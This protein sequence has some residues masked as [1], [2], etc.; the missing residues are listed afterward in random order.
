MSDGIVF[1]NTTNNYTKEQADSLKKQMEEKGLN[2]ITHNTDTIFGE[3]NGCSLKA[4]TKETD[5]TKRAMEL[6]F[7]QEM[8][9]I[10][11][12]ILNVDTSG[13]SAGIIDEN[14]YQYLM[15][16]YGSDSNGKQDESSYKG[17]TLTSFA[18]KL[19]KP[20]DGKVYGATESDTQVSSAN[21]S[22]TTTNTT[23]T[24][25]SSTSNIN[26]TEVSQ[27]TNTQEKSSE[28]INE[29]FAKNP[30][31]KQENGQYYIETTK[32]DADNKEGFDCVSRII[33][34]TY[35]V[36][37]ASE[38][39]QQILEQLKL[40]NPDCFVNDMIYPNQRINLI[41]A[42]EILGLSTETE[43]EEKI[44]SQK[45]SINAAYQ[46]AINVIDNSSIGSED[47]TLVSTL[48]NH[49]TETVTKT[50]KLN[51]GKIVNVVSPLNE[52]A[53]DQNTYCRVYSSQENL[54]A[55][56]ELGNIVID[57]DGNKTLS[58]NGSDTTYTNTKT[59][60][61]QGKEQINE[62]NQKEALD[63]L[64][65]KDKTEINTEKPEIN[66][67]ENNS[68]ANGL[69]ETIDLSK[70]QNQEQGSTNIYVKKGSTKDGKEI[71]GYE[72]MN[73]YS[74]E[75]NPDI[76]VAVDEQGKVYGSLKDTQGTDS[77]GVECNIS[78]IVDKD[79]NFISEIFYIYDDNSYK[80]TNK[81]GQLIQT[82][83]TDETI[84]NYDP[85]SGLELERI[86]KDGNLTTFS[87]DENGNKIENPSNTDNAEQTPEISESPENTENS[88]V[89]NNYQTIAQNYKE[90]RKEIDSALA[91]FTKANY[92]DN[93]TK[94][95]LDNGSTFYEITLED[96]TNVQ[97]TKDSK[98]RILSGSILNENGNP[99]II[100]DKVEL[101][102]DKSNKKDVNKIMVKF[103]ETEGK[104][105]KTVVLKS[106][107]LKTFPEIN[108]IDWDIDNDGK[109][110]GEND[111][112]AYSSTWGKMYLDV[113][114][115]GK[116]NNWTSV[117][118]TKY[119]PQ[120]LYDIDLDRY[121]DNI[122]KQQE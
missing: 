77:N 68:N 76:L 35:H 51:D 91:T 34:N 9:D 25:N 48:E 86:D 45:D 59:E 111:I 24:T 104:P 33:Y 60:E 61:T 36:S 84:H 19:D 116:A 12:D 112:H 99:M 63:E 22:A 62:E 114:N 119:K 23:D 122:K 16:A 20:R 92:A 49:E 106:N 47:G 40:A 82:K 13:E 103:I 56:L 102:E 39:G 29:L 73:L 38:K 21:N 121:E 71:G 31:I 115:D 75:E 80:I 41:D 96:N 64:E 105:T 46:T 27:T 98:G 108:H 107:D 43:K 53:Q 83:D 81:D 52:Q 11:W 18:L 120:L 93:Y 78:G 6:G 113:N 100:L 67:E 3:T 50:V 69:P 118:N 95:K 58:I 44:E 94:T 57:K 70:Y 87:Y 109:T 37:W 55:N 4:G 90:D 89:E 7:T 66:T 65:N 5:F 54:E 74:L 15:H 88:T 26:N 117:N 110:N 79:G 97:L 28:T 30:N 17:I 42:T 32:W 10:A 1:N 101:N 14:E 72:Q 85:Q 8:A 2:S